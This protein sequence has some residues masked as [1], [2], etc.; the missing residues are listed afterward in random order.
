MDKRHFL[1]KIKSL[2]LENIKLSILTTEI[3]AIS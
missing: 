3:I 1:L 2:A